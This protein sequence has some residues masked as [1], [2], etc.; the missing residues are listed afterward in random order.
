MACRMTPGPNARSGIQRLI[1]LEGVR[2][3][4]LN[5][6]GSHF[7]LCWGE[8]K[9]SLDRTGNHRLSKRITQQ[10][11]W[12]VVNDQQRFIVAMLLL[13]FPGPCSTYINYKHWQKLYF[14]APILGF[15]WRSSGHFHCR[16]PG[17][18]P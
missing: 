13:P 12:L 4:I 5:I 8:R 3:G 9:G 11:C 14:K 2:R 6:Y 17:F 1:F 15:P 7:I 10:S 16:W 18:D